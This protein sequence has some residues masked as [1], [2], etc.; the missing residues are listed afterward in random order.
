MKIDL[1]SKCEIC[2]APS[3]SR[4]FSKSSPKLEDFDYEQ[5]KY[6]CGAQITMVGGTKGIIQGCAQAHEV[7]LRLM[8]EKEEKGE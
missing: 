5:V 4:N 3:I 1:P 7:A 8:K 2:G 6:W